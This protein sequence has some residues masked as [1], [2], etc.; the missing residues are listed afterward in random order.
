MSTKTRAALL[1]LPGIAKRLIVIREYGLWFGLYS[2]LLK[3]RIDCFRL[4]FH[5]GVVEQTMA[6]DFSLGLGDCRL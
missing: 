2:R 6:M 3:L 5:L 4:F 1:R